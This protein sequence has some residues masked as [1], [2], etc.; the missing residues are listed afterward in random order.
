[1]TVP[2]FLAR[3]W[4]MLIG[5]F[6]GPLAFRFIMQPLAAVFIALRVA[7]RDAREGRPLYFFWPVFTDPVR[8]QE[9][10]HMAWKDVGKV[11]IVA[12]VLDIVYELIVYSWIYPGQALIVA[13]SL[14][15]I[16]YLLIRGPVTRILR[17]VRAA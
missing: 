15:V 16:P 9:L 1:M 8:R 2:D 3:H 14:A 12:L 17:R 10:I 5:R 4:Q 7:V 6:Q 13:V 11:F